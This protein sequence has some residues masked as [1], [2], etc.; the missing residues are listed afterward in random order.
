[1]SVTK[2]MLETACREFLANFN[3]FVRIEIAGDE[4]V[5]V[6]ERNASG[7]PDGELHESIRSAYVWGS[8]TYHAF[9]LLEKLFL[10]TD[11]PHYIYP[12]P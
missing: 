4:E 11:L 3:Y 1:M 8:P 12:A 10:A 5:T 6:Y 2:Q 9:G 7:D